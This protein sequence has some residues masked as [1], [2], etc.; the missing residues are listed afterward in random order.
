MTNT[1]SEYTKVTAL[2]RKSIPSEA[3]LVKELLKRETNGFARNALEKYLESLKQW[4]KNKSNNV[5][6]ERS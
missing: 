6:I 2:L 3:S 4:T 5:G 1:Q